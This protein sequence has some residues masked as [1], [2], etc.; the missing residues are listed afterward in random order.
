MKRKGDLF[1]NVCSPD[2]VRAAILAA[3]KGKGHYSEVRKIKKDIEKYV[4]ELSEILTKKQ[5]KN[6]E[7]EVF[8]KQSGDKT[9]VIYK[10]PFYPDRVVHHCIVQVLLPIWVRLLIRDT[11]STIPGRGIH[12]GVRR[13]KAALKDVPGTQYC[14]KFDIK[15][16]YPSVDHDVL[17]QILRRKIKDVDLLDLLDKIIDSAAG[18]PIG[19]YVSQWMGNVY[20]AYFDHFCKEQLHCKYYFRYCDDVV[21]LSDNKQF[22]HSV[23]VSINDYL[24]NELNLELK[25]NYQV[26]PTNTRGIDF[27][28]YR[29]FHTHTL[30]R[31]RIVKQMKRRLKQMKS[32]A[33][34]WGWLKHA[35]TYRLT[36]KY[37]TYERQFK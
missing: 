12:D 7:Y 22:L 23:L 8:E 15:K 18:I 16:Y 25:Q 14:L 3:M 26:F 11:F 32:M 17:K 35:D 31:K 21:I 1:K 9:R 29:F 24:V 37:Y 5:F 30:V 6:A 19:N 27:L 34:Y 10:L 33:S 13:M 4:A 2:N 28:G 20:L 36:N